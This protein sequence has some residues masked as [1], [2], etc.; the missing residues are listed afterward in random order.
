MGN[1]R[2]STHPDN[3]RLGEKYNIS[4]EIVGYIR[5]HYKNTGRNRLGMISYIQKKIVG[6]DKEYNN[7]VKALL[8]R[9]NRAKK[10]PPSLKQRESIEALKENINT[11]FPNK[12]INRQRIKAFLTFISDYQFV[13][14]IS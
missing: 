12:K 1:L 4:P 13:D 8:V 7:A 10:Y 6:I 11:F 3:I 5:S 2:E 9:E 14:I